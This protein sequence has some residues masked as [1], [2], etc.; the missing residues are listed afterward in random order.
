MKSICVSAF[1]LTTITSANVAAKP[2]CETLFDLNTS[3]GVKL[4]SCRG[5][6]YAAGKYVLVRKLNDKKALDYLAYPAYKACGPE[7]LKMILRCPQFTVSE[8]RN[9]GFV[10]EHMTNRLKEKKAKEEKKRLVEERRQKEYAEA[11]KRVLPKLKR[12]LGCKKC[13]DEQA[14]DGYRIAADMCS[15]HDGR[16]AAERAISKE[17]RYGRRHGVINMSRIKEDSD[18]VREME[19]LIARNQKDYKETLGRRFNLKRCRLHEK[20]FKGM[21]LPFGESTYNIYRDADE[22]G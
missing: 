6:L 3:K 21:R 16:I 4:E 20:I 22:D 17:R 14:V 11:I 5:R 19:E 13:N 15:M 10:L 18:Y 2:K 7:T 12:F 9:A 1:L 8:K